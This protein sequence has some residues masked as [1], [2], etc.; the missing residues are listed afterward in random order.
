MNESQIIDRLKHGNQQALKEVIQLYQDYVYTIE[1]TQDVFVKVYQKIGTYESRAKFST[2]LFTIVYRTALNYLDKKKIYFTESDYAFDDENQSFLEN[3]YDKN[4][5]DLLG[6]NTEINKESDH[7]L[8]QIIYKAID[9]LDMKQGI[10]ISLFYLKDFSVNEIAEI[11]Q[12]SA[13]TI[14]T[15]LFRGRENL[16]KV[17]LKSYSVEDLL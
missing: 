12:L 8:Q 6:Q 2:W 15:H 9:R 7:Q 5:R 16:K 3:I 4:N 13:N 17:L 1:V 11:M 10:V 14:K